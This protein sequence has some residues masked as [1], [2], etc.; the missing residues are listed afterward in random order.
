MSCQ[1]S[2]HS[3]G[4]MTLPSRSQAGMW[5]L[6][7][8]KLPSPG[9][10]HVVQLAS[11]RMTGATCRASLVVTAGWA[12]PIASAA[13]AFGVPEARRSSAATMLA[14]VALSFSV[15]PDSPATT[16]TTPVGP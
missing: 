6:A 9:T 4:A 16:P 1:N 15:R 2:N 7:F 3:P 13:P 5:M 14:V 11:G 12:T 10:Y 8:Q